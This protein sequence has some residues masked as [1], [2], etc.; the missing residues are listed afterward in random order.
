MNPA[1]S[2]FVVVVALLLGACNPIATVQKRERLTTLESATNTYRKLMRW[3]HFDQ[4]AQY[5][6]T[7]DG[8]LPAPDF[9]AMEHYRVTNF[10]FSDQLL[11]DTRTD[12]KVV[13]YIE[14]YNIDTGVAASVRDTQFWWYD[15]EQ[16]RWYLGTPMVTFGGG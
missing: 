8:E 5:L 10:S 11:S 1:V 12:A 16:E 15:E 14:Y 13:A 4:A 7:R 3:G 9:E 2:V 6:R